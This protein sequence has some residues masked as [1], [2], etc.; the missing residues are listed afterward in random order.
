MK[1]I[2]YRPDIDGLRAIAVLSILIFHINE[3][4]IPVLMLIFQ[5]SQCIT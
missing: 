1:H 2:S 3:K 5:F 4:W